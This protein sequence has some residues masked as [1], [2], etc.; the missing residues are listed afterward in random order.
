MISV[1]IATAPNNIQYFFINYNPQYYL[2]LLMN[3]LNYCFLLNISLNLPKYA[4]HLLL[5]V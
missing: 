1:E 4:Q 3:I 2:N 5:Q